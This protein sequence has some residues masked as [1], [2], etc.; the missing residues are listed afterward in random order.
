MGLFG[1]DVFGWTNQL[2]H[3]NDEAKEGP[4]FKS[5]ISGEAVKE[6]L[7]SGGKWGEGGASLTLRDEEHFYIVLNPGWEMTV[8]VKDLE[9]GKESNKTA[10]DSV[11]V[12]QV[13]GINGVVRLKQLK[14]PDGETFNYSVVPTI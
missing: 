8:F 9:T 11:P 2:Y 6:D 3:A 10:T 4:K 12:I 7:G 5:V 13:S 1:Y 14:T